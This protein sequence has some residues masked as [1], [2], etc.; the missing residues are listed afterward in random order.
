MPEQAWAHIK[1]FAP[2]DVAV[3]PL[4]IGGVL[5]PHFLL[6]FAG[7]AVLV[8]GGFLLD[9]LAVRSG[10]RITGPERREEAEERLLRAGT[11][12]FF[13]MLFATGGVILTPE[14]RTEADWP[15]WLQFGIAASMLSA[16]SCVLGAIGI[17]A[18]YGYGIALYGVFHLSDYP[19]FLGI[20]AYM[21]LTSCNLERL[22]ALRMTILY[23]SAC[24]SLMWAA[25][26]KWAYP[27]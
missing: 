11:G 12:A 17:L 23:A 19:I 5:A 3:P 7:F 10:R 8:F 13:M 9:R 24:G 1:W 26:E 21:A 22:R 20:A 16:P 25:I 4:P 6:S 14:L 18:L 15:A 2:Y 27:Q